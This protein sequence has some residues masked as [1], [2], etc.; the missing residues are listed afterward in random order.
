MDDALATSMHAIRSMVVT[1]IGSTPG[2]LAFSRDMFLNVPIFA[3][4]KLLHNVENIVS[5]KIS[6]SQTHGGVITT[7]DKDNKS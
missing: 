1:T 6:V 2:A 7:I 4:G 5:M 3:I